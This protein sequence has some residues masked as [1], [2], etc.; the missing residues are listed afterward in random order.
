[1][2]IAEEYVADNSSL[3]IFPYSEDNFAM[4][5]EFLATAPM[6]TFLQTR[7]YL[8]YHADRFQDVSLIIKDEKNRLV[9]LF[10]AA[11]DP[12]NSKRVVSHPG[13]TYGGLLHTGSLRGANMLEA[14]KALRHYYASHGFEAL[15][16][17]V[18][19]N[20]Y[21]QVPSADDLYALFRMGAVRYRCDLSCA[22]DLTNQPEPSLRRKRGLKKAQKNEIKVDFGFEL[23][24]HLWSVI[25]DNLAK[26]YGVQ[27]VHSAKEIIH[28][29]S[30]F[31]NNIEFIVG[32]YGT[33]ILGGVVLFLSPQVVHAQYIASSP[34]GYQ[35]G[36]LDAIFQIC[37]DKA[38]D[39]GKRYFSFG[40]STENEG[41]YL[42]TS[43][44]QFKSEFGASGVV[45]EFYEMNLRG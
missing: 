17:K 3:K 28:L 14:F 12:S 44:Y 8:S 29:Y 19:P 34:K 10:P 42:N 21:H 43:L 33:Q 35:L 30:L 4:W 32:L 2:D 20:I 37:I 26:K 36:L 16:Y 24:G 18:V 22:I 39:L 27:P 31:P 15:R 38:K 41:K 11:I 7:R 1:M 6:A 9:G 25:E 13:I 45:H 23:A 5:D 40:I